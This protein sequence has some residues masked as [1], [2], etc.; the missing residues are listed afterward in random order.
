MINAGVAD[1][2]RLANGAL[3]AAVYEGRHPDA[4]GKA[5][6]GA[7]PSPVA[8]A[9]LQ[10]PLFPKSKIDEVLPAIAD[11]GNRTAVET[12]A[13][14]YGGQLA[15]AFYLAVQYRDP[16]ATIA[17]SNAVS[18]RAATHVVDRAVRRDDVTYATALI[19]GMPQKLNLGKLISSALEAYEMNAKGASRVIDAAVKQGA[20]VLSSHFEKAVETPNGRRL[21]NSLLAAPNVTQAAIT[22]LE[23]AEKK[24]EETLYE[25][26]PY[27]ICDLD[28]DETREQYFGNA[29]YLRLRLRGLGV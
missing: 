27:G 10:H 28:A 22:G 18:I 1:P 17:A 15:V 4:H 25:V 24:Q 3:A 19:E 7:E 29:A 6:P 14:L 20:Q 12:A 8:T 23:R 5:A 11:S 21:I 16:A 2:D 9:I 26:S 13:G